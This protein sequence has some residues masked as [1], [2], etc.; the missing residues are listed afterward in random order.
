MEPSIEFRVAVT[1][2]EWLNYFRRH[3]DLTE[4]NFWRP[5]TPVTR[6]D[7]GTLWVFLLKPNIV[8]GY[9][10]VEVSSS[11]PISVA[12]DAFGTANGFDDRESFFARVRRYRHSQTTSDSEIGCV[13]LTSP[14]FFENGFDFTPFQSTWTNRTQ[15]TRR[16]SI[17][18]PEGMALWKELESR[19]PT[20]D[21]VSLVQLPDAPGVA[22]RL[23]TVRLGQGGF[24][25]RVIQAYER[26]CAITGERSLPALEAAH[27]KPFSEI[28]RHDT[29]NGIL[30][31]A[32]IHKLFDAGYV[33]IDPNLKFHVSPA[34][35]EQYSNGRVYYELD[36]RQVSIPASPMEQ[37]DRQYLDWHYTSIFRR[38]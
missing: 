9:A 8:S 12:W 33:T 31:R 30:L 5:G 15:P 14:V 20:S 34:L 7:P 32:D 2:T 35:K 19:A 28:R 17:S 1:D 25:T 36:D 26:R 23:L 38:S 11:L 10:I 16:Y 3:P 6:V 29:R 13:G 27:I 21:G 24:R 22:R 37:P 4:M 18:T